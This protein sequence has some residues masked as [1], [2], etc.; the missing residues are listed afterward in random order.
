MRGEIVAIDLETTGF[1][2]ILD[3]IIEIGAVRFSEGEIKDEFSVLIDPGIPIPPTITGLTGITDEMVT[4]A[5]DMSRVVP[6]LRDFVGDTTVLGHNVGFDLGFLQRHRVAMSNKVIDTYELAACLL[7]VAP[8]YSLISLSEYMGLS[9]ENAHRALDDAVATCQ[10][11]WK[12]WEKILKLPFN[13]LKEIVAAAENLDWDAKLPLI[14]ALRIRATTAMSKREESQGRPLIPFKPTEESQWEV[15]RANAK[16]TSMDVDEVAGLIEPE[17]QLT[18]FIPGYE[19]R[20]SQVDMLRAI[21]K[22]FNDGHHIMIEA[23]TGTGKS[24]AYLIPAIHFAMKN[25]ERVVVST[26]TIALQDQL[27]KK[28]IPLLQEALGL[29]FKAALAKGRANYLCPRRLEALRRRKPNSVDELRVLAKVLVWLQ[30]SDTGDRSEI[31]LRGFGEEMA[32]VRLS[33]QDEGCTMARCE[34]QMQ[35][36]CPF[37]KARR[38]ADGAH[39]VI[40]NHSL[41]LSDVQVGTRVLPDYRFV[42]ID[43]AHHLEDATTKGLSTKIDR[44][45]LRR[46]F[47]DLGDSEKGLFGEII[48]SLKGNIPPKYFGRI[49]PYIADIGEAIDGMDSVVEAYFRSLLDFLD[50]SSVQQTGDYTIVVRITDGMRATAAWDQVNK[51]WNK[52]QEFFEVISKAIAKVAAALMDEF[53]GYDIPNHED[54]I[55]SLQ[56]ASRY[57]QEIKVQLETFSDKPD[58]NMIYWCELSPNNPGYVS[59]NAAPL[60]VGPM[61]QKHLWESKEGAILTSATI[62]TANSF[63]FVRDRLNAP[64]SVVDELVVESPFDY[65]SSTMIYIPTDIPEPTERDRYQLMLERGIIE[66]ATAMDGRLLGL[67]TSHAQVRQTAQAI[68]ARL[69]L[70]GITVLDQSSGTSR[71]ILIE[72]FKST[73]KAVLLG[74]RSFWEGID[75]PGDDLEALVIARLP[76]AVPSDPIF[77]ARSETFENSFSEYA[78]PDAILRFRQGF[79]RLIRRQTDRGVVAI[80]DRRVSSKGY[81]RIFLQSLPNCTIRQ[82]PLANLAPAARQWMGRS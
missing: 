45:T 81:G 26:A 35:G 79:G 12:L 25:S 6:L 68:S 41:L 31:S 66:L 17:G 62:S 34:S 48:T 43:E 20:E 59:I 10:I 23:P 1:D 65:K 51:A 40:A 82:G 13:T 33:A 53:A 15:L 77:A 16:R 61:I 27:M 74:T 30:E 69:A 75:I 67:F 14:E 44:T 36:A 71:Q 52:L 2:P 18:Q 47:A 57:L 28:D 8:R 63:D 49:E 5:P 46:R 29:E 76:F 78:V 37:Y 55:A 4:G 22:S 9:L 11:Y 54:M 3:H 7:P 58:D 60:H 70:G 72:H 50:Q 56:A 64:K 38:Y 42:V 80:F 73:E 24:I 32:W 39:I 19:S 21:A